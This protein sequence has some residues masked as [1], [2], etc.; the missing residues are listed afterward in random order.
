M[1]NRALA[2]PAFQEHGMRLVF[3]WG[4]PASGKLTVAKELA[5]LTGWRLFHNHLTVDLLL[6][7]FPFGSK[8]FVELREQI[9]LSV[10]EAA[11]LSECP[12][13]IF[14]F[15]PEN[16]V[17]QSFLEETVDVVGEHGGH[18]EFVEIFCEESVVEK[19]M[20]TLER[21]AY[22][23]MLSVQDYR[24][25]RERGA[26]ATP[27]MPAPQMRV[28]TTQQSPREAA[29]QIVEGLGLPVSA[30]RIE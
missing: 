30:E 22:K 27:V 20:D 3:L 23:K 15:N 10:F 25:L 13:L 21:R 24:Q 26:F 16:T 12:G 11:A 18:V 14:T 7:V 8:E 6:S 4:L 29:T 9:W 5:E 19:R 2:F 28:D 17:R 1:T